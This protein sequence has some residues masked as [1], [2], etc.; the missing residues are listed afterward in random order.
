MKIARLLVPA[1]VVLSAIGASAASKSFDD[2]QAV[3]IGDQL[4]LQLGMDAG[5][6]AEVHNRLQS[7]MQTDRVSKV[8]GMPITGVFAYKIGEG[9][10]IVKVIDGQGLVRF[11]DIPTVRSLKMHSVT[12]GAQIGGS[13]ESGVGVMVGEGTPVDFGGEY[14][15]RAVAATAGAAAAS[16]EELIRKGAPGGGH[17][18]F[19]IGV[20]RGL[21]ATAAAGKLT[22]TVGP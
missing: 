22:I 12:G 7:W 2:S 5:K 20:A 4:M 18:V 16:S 14:S 21:S 17:R 19:L 9:G 3:A 11:A 10:L 6:R 8:G 15:V 13:A 1:L